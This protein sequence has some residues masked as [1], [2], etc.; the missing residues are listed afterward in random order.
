M[1]N[2]QAVLTARVFLVSRFLSSRFLTTVAQSCGQNLAG[3]LVPIAPRSLLPTATQSSSLASFSPHFL[4]KKLLLFKASASVSK[5][6]TEAIVT[7]SWSPNKFNNNLFREL[8]Y[9]LVDI[10]VAEMWW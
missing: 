1:N 9:R 5:H 6:T 2:L 10:L 8:R 4:N 7:R 3:G